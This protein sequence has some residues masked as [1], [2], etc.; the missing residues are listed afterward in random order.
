MSVGLLL[1]GELLRREYEHERQ[2]L[3]LEHRN[4]LEQEA[5][6]KQQQEEKS[7][8]QALFAEAENLQRA[9]HVRELVIAARSAGNGPPTGARG[10]S[11]HLQWRTRSTLSVRFSHPMRPSQSI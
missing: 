3:A 2:E 6:Q 5:R 4:W 11:G 1:A 10:Q 7:R 9:Q 8:M